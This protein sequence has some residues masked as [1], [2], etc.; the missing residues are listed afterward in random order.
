V[1]GQSKSPVVSTDTLQLYKAPG[2]KMYISEYF[3]SFYDSTNQL[4]FRQVL[5]KVHFR[6]LSKK[7]SNTENTTWLRVVIKNTNPT[8]T[9]PVVL[10]LGEF[11]LL[12][13]HEVNESGV[14]NQ[15]PEWYEWRYK[16][17]LDT[18]F[19]IP[20]KVSPGKHTT[21]FLKTANFNFFNKDYPAIFSETGFQEFSRGPNSKFLNARLFG[22]LCMIIGLCFFTGLFSFVQSLYSKDM[23]YA[24][25]TL[26]LW[27]NTYF[28]FA[29]SDRTFG[30][31]II[32]FVKSD[33][34]PLPWTIPGQYMVQIAYLLFVNSFLEIKSYQP[35]I[36]QFVR[37]SILVMAAGLIFAVFAV[38][39]YNLHLTD[40][41]DMVI[42]PTNLLILILVVR[43]IKA[44]IPQSKLLMIGTSGVL[45]AATFAG[46]EEIFEWKDIGIFWLIPIVA[47]GIGAVFEL[48]FFSLA[49]SQRMRL[50]QLENQQLQKNYTQQLEKDLEERVG[51][52]QIQ[53]K[54]LEEQRI[55]SLTSEFEQ[56]I[57]ETEISALRSQMNPHFIFNC[58]N[59]I[60]LYSLEND[61]QAAS[62]YLTKFSRL[63]RLVLENSRSEKVSLEKELETLQLY[64]QMEAMRFK[65]KVKFRIR[66]DKDIDQQF[67]EIPPL[68]L[69]PF[70]ENAIWHGLMHKEEGGLIQID[71]T[72]PQEQLLHIEIIDDGIGREQS[73]A[74]KSKSATRNKSYG[75]K[76]TNERIE[77]INQIYKTN[78]KVEII[79][80]KNDSGEATGTKVV[81]NIPI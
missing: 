81:L 17:A 53:N 33:G 46:L 18:R 5:K 69:Q 60:K 70:V 79:D 2:F 36:Y 54:Q 19:E 66:I 16:A 76:V 63:I 34:L 11:R 51:I 37:F 55:I 26:Y 68:L 62:E 50:I 29:E 7:Q 43:I 57:A 80:L 23:T 77:L 59:S 47:F 38:S 14:Y 3:R 39:N 13:V 73:A 12:E 40:Y 21:F 41:A 42:L 74:Y 15:K 6:A 75:M 65:D 71:I 58:L 49:L 10:Y 20:I 30:L 44:D 32:P 8:D 61:S 24:Y 52:I 56:K 72:L 9:L 78:T 27:A 4:T 35:K 22:F 67:I 25:W 64:I 1:M 28:F 31:K 45:A 48:T